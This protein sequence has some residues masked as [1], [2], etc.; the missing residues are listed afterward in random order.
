[1][2]SYLRKDLHHRGRCYL[3]V[4][5]PIRGLPPLDAGL[6]GREPAPNEDVSE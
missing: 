2:L 1:M 5:S 4:N 3:D 6:F